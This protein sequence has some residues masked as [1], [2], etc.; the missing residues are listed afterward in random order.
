[1]IPT[2]RAP[3]PPPH[4]HTPSS[5]SWPTEVPKFPPVQTEYETR[6]D[7]ERGGGGMFR[8]LL[9]K[10]LLPFGE[11]VLLKTKTVIFGGRWRVF[12]FPR[13]GRLSGEESLL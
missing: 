1:M 6:S 5:D 12:L 2:L 4:T 10:G 8:T 3:S 7:G 9:E 13:Q 11:S